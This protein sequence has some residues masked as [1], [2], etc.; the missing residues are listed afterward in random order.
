MENDF[1]NVIDRCKLFDKIT[2]STLLTCSQALNLILES[3]ITAKIEV[4]PG[5]DIKNYLKKVKII[6]KSVNNNDNTSS[7]HNMKPT[8][9]I[10]NFKHVSENNI[11]YNNAT[12]G[13]DNK[14]NEVHSR[15]LFSDKCEI[16]N[17]GLE[18]LDYLGE[19]VKT[20]KNNKIKKEK[21]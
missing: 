10:F 3:I 5:K 11:L 6:D 12:A 21:N 19:K 15:K 7:C 8:T 14:Y 1:T 2:S 9:P 17:R 13:G 16:E 20:D 18:K 4:R